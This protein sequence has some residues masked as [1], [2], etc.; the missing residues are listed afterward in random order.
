[1]LRP[2]STEEFSDEEAAHRATD[3]LR[4]ALATPYKPQSELVGKKRRV[5][6][7]DK[8]EPKSAPKAPEGGE[9]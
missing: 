6:S 8:R 4:R 7:E 5:L 3:A 1:M 9:A 2:K